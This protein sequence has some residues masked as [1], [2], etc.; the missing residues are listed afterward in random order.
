MCYRDESAWQKHSSVSILKACRQ[1]LEFYVQR[2]IQDTLDCPRIIHWFP[3]YPDD[4]G[5]NDERKSFEAV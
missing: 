3:L 5:L 2:Y 1:A 4:L